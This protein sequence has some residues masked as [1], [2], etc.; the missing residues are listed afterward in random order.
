MS[1]SASRVGLGS[2][3]QN[4]LL[5]PQL[6]DVMTPEQLLE[7]REDKPARSRQQNMR[8]R[9]LNSILTEQDL[10]GS[11]V[12]SQWSLGA[13][14][15]RNP[16]DLTAVE[17]RQVKVI[18]R[19]ALNPTRFQHSCGGETS[20][21]KEEENMGDRGNG[22]KTIQRDESTFG[23]GWGPV[24]CH[25]DRD[26]HLNSSLR[27]NARVE[28][29]IK[30]E[31][32]HITTIQQLELTLPGFPDKDCSFVR[33]IDAYQNL[34]DEEEVSAKAGILSEDVEDLAMVA[35]SGL[36]G[37]PR[38]VDAPE[39]TAFT[40]PGVIVDESTLSAGVAKDRPAIE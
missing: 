25:S 37:S 10:K 18:K 24:N 20:S 9:D 2:V 11:G 1:S 30:Q 7:L 14:Y 13:P 23:S 28:Q 3:S 6:R 8:V 15:L 32:E 17:V 21:L 29:L 27:L 4:M 33:Q 38:V 19:H 26:A 12:P 40:N 5:T 39:S 34:D 35:R 22:P 16:R 31:E 36:E